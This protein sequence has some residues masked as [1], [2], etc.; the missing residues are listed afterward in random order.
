[1][2]SFCLSHAKKERKSYTTPFWLTHDRDNLGLRL[3][4]TPLLGLC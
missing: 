4:S 3:M 2:V 1:V